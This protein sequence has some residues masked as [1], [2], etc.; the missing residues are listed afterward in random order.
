MLDS[1]AGEWEEHL[2][3]QNAHA[4][5]LDTLRNANR[6]LRDQVCVLVSL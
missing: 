2:R 5:E 3:A 4:L 1:F 6:S